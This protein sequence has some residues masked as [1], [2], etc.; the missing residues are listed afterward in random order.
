LVRVDDD[1]GIG[2]RV[3][4]MAG[5]LEL[6]SQFAKVVDFT[7]EDDPDRT[8]LVVD[9]LVAGRQIDDAQAPHSECDPLIDPRAFV[10]R[11]TMADDVAHPAHERAARFGSEGRSG[12]G[13]LYE[14]GDAAHEWSVLMGSVRLTKHARCGAGSKY[15][16]PC[17][18]PARAIDPSTRPTRAN[19][20]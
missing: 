9:R 1:L 6:G 15:S 2:C 14:T 13:G 3:E 17:R 12:G 5:S 19:R 20:S 16:K 10:V 4:A 18:P 11:A 8:I 7:V